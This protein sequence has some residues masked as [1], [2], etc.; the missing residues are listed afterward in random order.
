MDRDYT[1]GNRTR[2]YRGNQASAEEE[3]TKFHGD[4]LFWTQK[5]V[6]KKLRSWDN[7]LDELTGIVQAAS[8]ITAGGMYPLNIKNA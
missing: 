3:C 2:N 6:D 8:H 5:F 1:V 4:G 7:C